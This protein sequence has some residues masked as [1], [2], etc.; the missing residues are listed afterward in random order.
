MT[1]KTATGHS[2]GHYEL[3]YAA[4]RAS[5]A[6]PRFSCFLYFPENYSFE[7]ADQY[8][9]CVLIHGSSRT[10]H[11]YRELF[12]D[13]AEQHRCIV[14]APLFPVGIT[15][16]EDFSSYKFIKAG[17]LRYDLVL[18]SMIEEFS[19]RYGVPGERFLMHGF[20]GG[21]HFVH[22][23][24]YLHAQRLMALSIGAP[25]MVTLL[26]DRLD[27]HC[28]IRGMAELLEAP[29][30]WQAMREV[31]VQMVIG[32]DDTETWEITIKPDNRYWMPGVND[33]GSNRLQRME[34]LRQSFLKAGI[35]V[36]HDVVAGVGHEGYRLLDTVKSFFASVLNQQRTSSATRLAK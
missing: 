6:D 18:L 35:T 19:T 30:A 11:I 3:G 13:F 33:A 28:G 25:G 14:L 4:C 1:V 17:E 36:Q 22:R 21:G 29:I 24:F 27:W 10:P 5:Q 2:F 34:A 8:T 9:L 12:A 16:A 26:D 15:D 23:F 31:P 20:S 7:T 32:G